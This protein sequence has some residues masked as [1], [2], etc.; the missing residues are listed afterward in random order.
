MDNISK[1]NQTTMTIV[2]MY[3]VTLVVVNLGW[4][5]L[6]YDVPMSA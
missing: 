1:P 3:R 2:A 5:D 4:V 6:Y